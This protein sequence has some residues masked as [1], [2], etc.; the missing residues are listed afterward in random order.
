[1]LSVQVRSSAS[2]YSLT[3]SALYGHLSVQHAEA[4]QRAACAGQAFGSESLL[5]A[6]VWILIPYVKPGLV[7]CD[8]IKNL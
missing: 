4:K 1:M 3:L 8:K 2:H 6:F 7:V 5:I